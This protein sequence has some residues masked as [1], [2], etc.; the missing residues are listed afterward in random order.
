MFEYLTVPS[1]FVGT[2]TVLN[3][4]TF[5]WNSGGAPGEQAMGGGEP[6]G[7]T[8]LHPPFNLVSNYRDPGKVNIN[9]ISDLTVWNA[10]IG[11]DPTVPG[12]AATG[13]K[14]ADVVSSRQGYPSGAYAFDA[15]H[16]SIF[17]N[18]FRSAAGA[19][20]VPL[21]TLARKPANVTL[22]RAGKDLNGRTLTDIPVGTGR[23]YDADNAVNQLPLMTSNSALAAPSPA[24][25]DGTR[26]AYFT[27]QGLSHL[28]SK[29]T[30]RS[31]VYAV[32]ITVG[33]FEVT[34]WYGINSATGTPFTTGPQVFD[35]AHPDGYQLGAELG[36]DTG[37]VERHRAFY[38]IDR[39]IPV[40][41]QHGYDINV[42]N[43]VLLKRFIE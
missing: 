30:T 21:A 32:W 26:N 16:P 19:D 5:A 37:Q 42:N 22:F 24:Y 18:P 29:L 2:Q 31:N 17:S 40:G 35:T 3:P 4:Q 12:T 28:T 7:T 15:A 9:T 33:Y 43:A 20:M 10:I 38:I 13:P 1:P 39:S 23:P 14:F 11:G 36:S 25:E 6:N 34:P 41:F 8:G 27:Y